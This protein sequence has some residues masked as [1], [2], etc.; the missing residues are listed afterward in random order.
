M[1]GPWIFFSKISNLVPGIRLLISSE[2][3]KE[4]F[5]LP[6]KKRG[7]SRHNKDVERQAMAPRHAYSRVPRTFFLKFK[8]LFFE[9]LALSR[10]DPEF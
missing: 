8:V 4:L 2:R 7:C 10:Q 6:L 3:Q 1:D 5:P 9:I